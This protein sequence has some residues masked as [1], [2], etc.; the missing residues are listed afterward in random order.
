MILKVGD[1]VLVVHRRLYESDRQRFF[2]GTVLE[3]DAGLVAVEGF[4]FARE[5]IEGSFVRKPDARTRIIPLMS[6]SI[7]TYRL[8]RGVVAESVRLGA[9][10][11]SGRLILSDGRDLE[12]DLSEHMPAG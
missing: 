9:T 10:T 2:V 4:S 6:G 11:E 12:M 5:D 7:F 1:V 3:Y 8:P